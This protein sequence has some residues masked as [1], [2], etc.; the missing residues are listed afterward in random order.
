MRYRYITNGSCN[1]TEPIYKFRLISHR[2]IG[3]T[4]K[5]AGSYF[6]RVNIPDDLQLT[7]YWC[8]PYSTTND[9]RT[10]GELGFDIIMTMWDGSRKILPKGADIE[11][12]SKEQ[13]LKW[14]ERLFESKKKSFSDIVTSASLRSK[15][16]DTCN[17]TIL[18]SNSIEH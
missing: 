10:I 8:D 18:K 3:S 7:K 11:V 9:T 16:T 17:K 6:Y 5:V 14:R 1:P 13:F 12:I 4:A 2:V 15:E